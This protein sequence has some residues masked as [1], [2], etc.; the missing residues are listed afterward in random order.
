[1]TP[2]KRGDLQSWLSFKAP[3]RA[4]LVD[5]TCLGQVKRGGG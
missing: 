5:P 3:P 4:R 1:M 2:A